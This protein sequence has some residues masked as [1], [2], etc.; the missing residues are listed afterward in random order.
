MTLVL[1]HSGSMAEPAGDGMTKVQKLRQAASSFVDLMLQRDS[2]GL[3]RFDDTAQRIMNVTDVGPTSGGAGTGRDTAKGFL[4]GPML[5]P[6]GATSI[7]DGALKGKLALDD[8][9]AVA[10]PHYD[11]TA[12]VVLTDGNENTPPMLSTVGSS[13]TA[14]T[15]AI[16]FG[17]ADNVSTAA[18]NTLTQNHNGY[19][20]VTGNLTP[21]QSN[22]L[23]KYFLQILAGITNANVIV[24][25]QSDL[26]YGI[27]HR[28][29]FSVTEADYGM[30]V[31]V[32]S[33]A[34]RYINFYLETP[35]GQI[36]NPARAV[37]EATI[38]FVVT[39]EV[40]YYRLSLPALPGPASG[41]HEGIWHAVLA[42]AQN[43]LELKE[44]ADF[45]GQVK[46]QALPYD[47]VVHTYS[48]LVFK[49]NVQQKSLEPGA[50]VKVRASLTEYD[51][52]VE[53][54]T[55]V[56]AEITDPNGSS[57]TLALNEEEAGQFAANFIAGLPGVYQVRARAIGTTFNATSFQREGTLTAATFVGGD[58]SL[59]LSSIVNNLEICCKRFGRL[60]IL[61]LAITLI[62]GF[63]AA[64]A[65]V[66]AA[67]G[68]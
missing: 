56:W 47:L 31:I 34:P 15:F 35:E 19:L 23:T 46:G 41:S 60:L 66:I 1:N 50:E 3:F 22:R 2:L 65:L 27:Q 39:K 4:M 8:A 51:V 43:D 28:I 30:D 25:P 24:D 11:V 57:T 36:I 54:R 16:G 26:T 17:T 68:R 21:D 7:G 10:S 42:L 13:I 5:D 52:P 20:L 48:S 61:L 58:R 29:P 67:G 45:V 12:I 63:I 53:R 18:L 40:S 55:N 9:Q 64:I 59:D 44:G 62:V 6:A 14:N 38:D 33:P 37:A 32:L 49:M